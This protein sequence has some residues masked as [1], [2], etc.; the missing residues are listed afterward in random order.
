[1][2]PSLPISQDC[3]QAIKKDVLP[4]L[5]E[6]VEDSGISLKERVDRYSERS[7]GYLVWDHFQH[8]IE[9]RLGAADSW[10]L[11]SSCDEPVLVYKGDDNRRIRFRVCRVSEEN[12]LPTSNQNARKHAYPGAVHLFF[13]EELERLFKKSHELVLGYDM[14]MLSGIGQ[15]TLQILYTSEGKIRTEVLAILYN[16]SLHETNVPVVPREV[17][18]RGKPSRRS[19]KYDMTESVEIAG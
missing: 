8:G 3:L 4:L 9:E 2:N 12:R 17:I 7:M 10:F 13:T 18:P 6:A 11:P 16:G 1:M 14:G 19:K 15:V 5:L